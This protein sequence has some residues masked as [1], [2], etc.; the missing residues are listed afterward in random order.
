MIEQI[1]KLPIDPQL[2][3]LAQA[4][5]LGEVEIAPVKSGPRSALRPRLPNWQFCGLSPPAH[6]PVLGSTAGDERVRVQPL[7]GARLRDAGN[8]IVA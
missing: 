7:D 5:P 4:E 8:R 1:E 3:A 6:A 2:R